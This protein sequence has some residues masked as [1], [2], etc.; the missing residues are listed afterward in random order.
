M[1]NIGSSGITSTII[2]IAMILVT[3]T[4]AG[5]I[6]SSTTNNNIDTEDITRL[7]NEILDEI[8]TY[9]QIKDQKG[10]Y[11]LINNEYQ[12]KKIAI[13]VSPLI[14]Q[15]IDVSKLMIQI[16][17]GEN[18]R[19]LSFA[20]SAKI[21]DNSLF[22]HPLWQYIDGTN[23]GLITILDIDNS[24]SDYNIINENTDNCYIIFELPTSMT[25]QKY[26]EL[27]VRLFPSSGI[28][29]TLNLKAPMP[30]KSIVTFE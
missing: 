28:S 22:E 3:I 21:S 23:F 6:T 24:I 2:L 29:R 14:S 27:T 30:M 8:S 26:Q 18:I 11:Y 17:N 20:D 16:D 9:L 13:L 12:I 25:M 1:N 10:K 15:N 4:A 5:I 7:T 19:I